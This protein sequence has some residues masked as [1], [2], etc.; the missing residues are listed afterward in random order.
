MGAMR[1]VPAVKASSRQELYKRLL[2][3]RAFMEAN[4]EAELTIEVIARQAL[5]NRFYFIELFRR[6]FGLTP[7]AY[8]RNRKLEC[9]QE[10]LQAGESVTDVCLRMGYKSVGSFSN[11]FKAKFGY[12]PSAVFGGGFL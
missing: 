9:A 3:A 10:L 5:L 2:L 8:L 6:T 4:V 7:Y 1:Q 12:T 11:T